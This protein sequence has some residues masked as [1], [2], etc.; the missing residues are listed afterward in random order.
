MAPK[1]NVLHLVQLALGGLSLVVMNLAWKG[2]QI[3]PQSQ[4]LLQSS[5][6]SPP[7]ILQ[8]NF[9]QRQLIGKELPTGKYFRSLSGCPESGAWL[10]DYFENYHSDDEPFVFLNFGCNKGYD[11]LRVANAVSRQGDLFDKQKWGVA[12]NIRDQGVCK[13]GALSENFPQPNDPNLPTRKVQVHCVEAMPQTVTHLQHAATATSANQ[14]GFH[15]HNYAMVGAGAEPSILFPNPRG[16]TGQ[17][18]FGMAHCQN[19]VPADKDC[20]LVPAITVDQFVDKHVTT[21]QSTRIPYVSI[22]VE[23]YDYTIMKAAP[24]T[25]QRTD[26]LEFEFH[27]TGDW[28]YQDL[29]EAIDMLQ[30][31]AGLVCYFAGVHRLWRITHCWQ[32]TYGQFHAWSN[33]ACVNPIHQPQLAQKMESIFDATLEITMKKVLNKIQIE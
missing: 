3:A 15:V 21:V 33:V 13:Q 31:Q 20:T 6:R 26:Y 12:L 19:K 2:T 14:H 28:G 7:I 23:G 17:E 9:L 16:A 1:L 18:W 27:D 22:D 29:K 8:C 5:P 25:L 10:T 24:Q 32:E 30:Q 11:S 4:P